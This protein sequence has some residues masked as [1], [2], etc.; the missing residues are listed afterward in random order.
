MERRTRRDTLRLGAGLGAAAVGARLVGPIRRSASAGPPPIQ[1][2]PL[3]T[4]ADKIGLHVGAPFW[5]RHNSGPDDPDLGALCRREF[6][7]S[8]LYHGWGAF[9]PAPGVW[10][11]DEPF[12][13]RYKLLGADNVV[14]YGV[15]DPIG[16][17]GP[18]AMP[19]WLKGMSRSATIDA[20]QRYVAAVV[21]WGKGKISSIVLVGETNSAPGWDILYDTLGLEYVEIAFTTAR[22]TDPSAVLGYGDFNNHTKAMNRYLVTKQIVDRLKGLKLIDFV[23]IECFVWA[24][25][26]WNRDEIIDC[27]Q[28]YGLPI[29][30]TE[31]A[32]L[33]KE[34]QG[35]TEY[36]YQYEADIYRTFFGAALESGVCGDF[37]LGS[38]CD[39]LGGVDDP[40]S[41][42]PGAIPQNEPFPFDG[43]LRPKPAYYA[44]QSVLQEAVDRKFP[45][46]RSVP[47][48]SSDR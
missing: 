13:Q 22:R 20:L 7:T 36:R 46:R 6:N 17:A 19:E 44:M 2:P 24:P 4:L 41:G 16:V 25:W 26:S 39:G 43:Q 42:M 11:P 34:I 18:F 31:F 37:I 21:E 40:A 23:G 27:F 14:L 12:Y 32:V 3:R 48:L 45:Y 9:E 47:L 5:I 10:V 33:M 28:S 30:I 15:V 1:G 38:P 35:S 8:I 29:A